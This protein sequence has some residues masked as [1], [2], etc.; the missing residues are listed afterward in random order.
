MA[1]GR[2]VD[3]NLGGV[4]G[5]CVVVEVVETESGG[6]FGALGLLAKESGDV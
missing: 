1:V 3:L 4:V 5:H 6:V 2:G